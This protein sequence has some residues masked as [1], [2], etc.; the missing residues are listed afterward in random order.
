MAK[1]FDI[2]FHQWS[3]IKLCQVIFIWNKKLLLLFVTVYKMS[4]IK[5]N[6]NLWNLI[7]KVIIWTSF[8]I[9]VKIQTKYYM[10]L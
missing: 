10:F 5:S 8:N 6:Q 2:H 1:Y 4:K 3:V 9:K 7:R